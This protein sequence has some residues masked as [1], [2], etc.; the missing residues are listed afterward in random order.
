MSRH[1]GR[2]GVPLA[3]RAAPART[4]RSGWLLLS[5]GLLLHCADEAPR[6][7]QAGGRLHFTWAV[8]EASLASACDRQQAVSFRATVFHR[9]AVV[10]SYAA[11]CSDFELTT[12]TFVPDAEYMTRAT[13]VDELDLPRSPTLTSTRFSIEP[14][15]VVDVSMSFDADGVIFVGPR[16]SPIQ[17]AVQ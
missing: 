17:N 12:D 14:D 1:P 16:P 3:R 6:A 8:G 10:D 5:A 11:P 2:I 15:A 13:L 7:E 4:R 9:G